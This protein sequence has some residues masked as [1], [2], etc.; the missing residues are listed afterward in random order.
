MGS[1]SINYINFK[2]MTQQEFF[3]LFIE[4]L[5]I[6]GTQVGLETI[7][8]SLQEW[9]SMGIMITIGLVADNFGVRLTGDDM[10]KLTTLNS[11]I[12]KI[13]VEKFEK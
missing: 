13:G 9:D 3:E 5:E 8:S 7:L 1:N 2:V 11:L 4:E 12:E 10:K 6:E